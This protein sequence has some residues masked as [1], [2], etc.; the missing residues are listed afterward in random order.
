MKF[1]NLQVYLITDQ[2]AIP[3]TRGLDEKLHGF[4]HREP[5]AQEAVTFG[6]TAPASVRPDYLVKQVSTLNVPILL[7][8]AKRTEKVIPPAAVKDLL[9]KKVQEIGEKEARAVPKK[10]QQ[11]IKEEIIFSLLP[12]ALTKS[13]TTYAYIDQNATPPLLVVDASTARRADDFVSLLRKALGSLPVVPLYPMKD[14]S[15]AMTNMVAKSDP[16]AVMSFEQTAVLE[17]SEG[18]GKVTIRDL[19][20]ESDEVATHIDNGMLVTKIGLNYNDEVTFEL[21][22]DLQIKKVKL[23]DGVVDR[24][25][26]EA[27]ECEDEQISADVLI[28]ADVFRR[29]ISATAE[30]FGGFP[31]FGGDDQTDDGEEE[32]A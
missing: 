19:D 23:L 18:K 2:D 32:L 31:D 27:P 21:N 10:E 1:K 29:L 22:Q 30:A 3:A 4:Q 12:N 24:I 8:A 15:V 13:T 20:L 17:A 6:F 5:G 7:L 9:A 16:P 11:R 28:Q 26:D 25:A 14:A